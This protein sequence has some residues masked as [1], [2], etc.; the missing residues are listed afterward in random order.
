[1]VLGFNF[2]GADGVVAQPMM[3]EPI[4][5][6]TVIQQHQPDEKTWICWEL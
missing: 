2:L 4:A 3:L 6:P 5:S 1:M